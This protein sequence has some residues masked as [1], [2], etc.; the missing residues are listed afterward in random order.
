MGIFFNSP[1]PKR[2]SEHELKN[3]VKPNVTSNIEHEKFS[4]R[5]KRDMELVFPGYMDKDKSTYHQGVNQHEL[6]EALG[7][8]K[9]EGWSETKLKILEKQMGKRM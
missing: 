6:K 2:V 3:K 5:E 8:L 4:Q 9:K 1:T 7:V